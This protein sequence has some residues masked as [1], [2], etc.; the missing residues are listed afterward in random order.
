MMLRDG[1]SSWLTVAFIIAIERG[2]QL[3]H[4]ENNLSARWAEGVQLA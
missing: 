1:E 3:D 2:E 4:R